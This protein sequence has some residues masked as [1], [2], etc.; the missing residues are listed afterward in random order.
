M[1]TSP[2]QIFPTEN[3]SVVR[4]REVS[5]KS[6]FDFWMRQ[7]QIAMAIEEK[8]T[9][10]RPNC[11][12]RDPT[13]R[14]G[15]NLKRCTNLIRATNRAKRKV[16][17]NVYKFGQTFRAF[18]TLTFRNPEPSAEQARKSFSNF[19]RNLR[20]LPRYKSSRLQYFARLERGEKKGRL[21]LH[22]LFNLPINKAKI[23]RI[24]RLKAY[25]GGKVYDYKTLCSKD[26]VVAYLMKYCSKTIKGNGSRYRQFND[27]LTGKRF[28]YS[29]GINVVPNHVSTQ[30]LKKNCENGKEII[31]G[32]ETSMKHEIPMLYSTVM[33]SDVSLRFEKPKQ[34]VVWIQKN[35]PVILP[36]DPFFNDAETLVSAEKENA[37]TFSTYW[38]IFSKMRAK[39]ERDKR[40]ENALDVKLVE[41]MNN[42]RAPQWAYEVYAYDLTTYSQKVK[43]VY[44]KMWLWKKFGTFD[45]EKTLSF[46]GITLGG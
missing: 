38:R 1:A 19:M 12:V 17:Y 25:S 13:G 22:V 10:F 6:D 45:R 37:K 8:R 20:K 14:Y 35:D 2:Q 46:L 23:L 24:W 18:L 42:F 30:F 27:E 44:K 29:H 15:F 9:F 41:T 21:H 7:H 16:L 40:R 36:L 43:F 33:K 5:Q 31:I 26:E 4:N 32:M 34:E 11:R 3:F 28:F 39:F